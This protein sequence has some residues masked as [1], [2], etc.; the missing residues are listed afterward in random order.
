[1]Y[2]YYPVHSKVEEDLLH[3]CYDGSVGLVIH[4]TYIANICS[5]IKPLPLCS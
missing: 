4:P 5:S 2:L 1:M 3:S